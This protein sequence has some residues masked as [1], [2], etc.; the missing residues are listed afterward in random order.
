MSWRRQSIEI[1]S[2][3]SGPLGALLAVASGPG[4]GALPTLGVCAGLTAETIGETSLE[5]LDLLQAKDNVSA[6]PHTLSRWNR[7]G[8]L[9]IPE[10]ASAARFDTSPASSRAPPRDPCSSAWSRGREPR[11]R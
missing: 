2:T 9:I 8:G 1:R 11:L 3:L 6:R 7:Q 4:K 10:R 5:A